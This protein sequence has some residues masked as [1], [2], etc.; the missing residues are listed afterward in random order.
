[1]AQQ[2]RRTQRRRERD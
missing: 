2:H 1:M